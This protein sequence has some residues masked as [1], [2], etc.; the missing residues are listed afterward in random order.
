LAACNIHIPSPLGIGPMSRN[1]VDAALDQA[2]AHNSRLMLIASRRQ[3]EAEP[4]GG[5]YVQGWT[6]ETFAEY[7][8]ERD[9][10]HLVLLCRDHGGPWQHPSERDAGYDEAAAIDSSVASFERDIAAGFDLLHIDTCLEAAAEAEVSDAIARLLTIYGACWELA[11][12]A[13]RAIAFE[14]GFERQGADTD[15]PEEF[16]CQVATVMQRLR[17]S[18]LPSPTFIVAQT[19]TKVVATR[20]MGGVLSCPRAVLHAVKELA[21]TCELAGA[22][23]K[24][25]NSDYLPTDALRSLMS[26]GVAAINVAPELGV[27]ESRVFLDILAQ[28][29]QDRLRDDFLALAFGS[30]AWEK[31][32]DAGEDASD[33]DKAVLAG[34]YVFATEEFSE[35]KRRASVAVGKRHDSIDDQ[36]RR[37]VGVR[38]SQLMSCTNVRTVRREAPNRRKLRA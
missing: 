24:A 32:L 15:A 26:N 12:R 10:D 14:V 37:A 3:I 34:H 29:R 13:G 9:P 2:Y 35:I 31:W 20:N 17:R 33:F 7:V 30:R 27:L 36:L 6:T 4:F 23:L 22:G 18:A 16:R 21:R 5:G 19:G 28:A 38:L 11:Q 1:T 25:H 8:R